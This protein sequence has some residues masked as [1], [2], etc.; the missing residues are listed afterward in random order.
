MK[1]KS[2]FTYN[3]K[4]ILI[5][6]VPMLLIASCSNSTEP[7]ELSSIDISQVNNIQWNLTSVESFL[8]NVNLSNYEPFKIVFWNNRFWGTDNCNFLR[9]DYSIINDSLIIFNGSITEIGCSSINLFPFK[10]LF[11]NPKIMMRGTDLILLRNYT[12]FVYSSNFT[13]DISQHSFL[14]D[15]LSLKSSN[16]I[17]ISFFNSLRLYPKL[18]LSF[19]RQFNIQWYNKSPANTSFINQYAGVFGINENKEILFTRIN[20]FYEGNGISID[21]WE[22]VDRIIESKRFEYNANFLKI[23]NTITNTYYEFSK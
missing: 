13:K 4:L 21:D 10:H 6:F 2:M 18:I 11:G 16:D 20:S 19:E 23:I 8:Q 3:I 17:N 5:V 1:G 7:E 9:G 14:N 12:T 22:L 15:T